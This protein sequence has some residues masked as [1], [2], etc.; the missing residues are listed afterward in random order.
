MGS[1]FGRVLWILLVSVENKSNLNY[2]NWKEANP[3]LP[4]TRFHAALRRKDG[5][6]YSGPITQ[7][8]VWGI[9]LLTV[10]SCIIILVADDENE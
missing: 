10:A 9:G 1:T 4:S 6:V 2:T 8:L 3:P 5:F 7:A